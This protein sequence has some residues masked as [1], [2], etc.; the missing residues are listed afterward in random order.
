M[1]VCLFVCL[2]VR[3]FPLVCFGQLLRNADKRIVNI[4][5]VYT[6]RNNLQLESI[7]Y[8]SLINVESKIVK[9]HGRY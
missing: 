5:K 4:M 2:S 3:S 1:F 8:D 7:I 6:K 9:K